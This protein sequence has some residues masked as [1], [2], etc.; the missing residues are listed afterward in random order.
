MQVSLIKNKDNQF[1]LRSSNKENVDIIVNRMGLK[2]LP[3]IV[4]QKQITEYL[5]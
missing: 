3:N 1:F 4:A 2:K 5:K